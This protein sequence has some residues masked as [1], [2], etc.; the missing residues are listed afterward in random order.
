MYSMKISLETQATVGV[1]FLGACLSVAR[2]H[3]RASYPP[4]TLAILMFRT[5]SK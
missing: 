3:S 1:F 5:D 4:V 2:G